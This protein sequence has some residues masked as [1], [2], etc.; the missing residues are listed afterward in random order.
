MPHGFTA[1]IL[2]NARKFCYLNTQNIIRSVDDN[3]KKKKK[4]KKKKQKK[5]RY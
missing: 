1:D 5:N 2:D 3:Y 4:K